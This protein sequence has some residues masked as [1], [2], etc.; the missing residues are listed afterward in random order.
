MV[1]GGAKKTRLAP[2]NYV[3]KDLSVIQKKKKVNKKL[4][5]AAEAARIAEENARFKAQ[6]EIQL[7]ETRNSDDPKPSKV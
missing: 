6:N 3:T 4:A 7:P 2:S 1:K 5:A